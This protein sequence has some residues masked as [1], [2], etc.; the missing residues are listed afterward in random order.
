LICLLE[1]D[2]LITVLSEKQN[3]LKEILGSCFKTGNEYL[4]FCPK[5]NHHKRKLSVN[6]EKNAFK[7]WIC[8]YRSKSILSLIKS[9]GSQQ[10]LD[11]W[12]AITGEIDF[13]FEKQSIKSRLLD[14][15]KQEIKKGEYIQLPKEFISL[16]GN[17]SLAAGQARK[18]LYD[19]GVLEEDINYWKIG[20]AVEGEYCN[21]IIIPLCSNNGKVNFF[22]SRTYLN[23][24]PKYKNPSV[25]K[26]IVFNE[27][28]I[29]WNKPIVLVEGIFDAIKAGENSIPLL[30]S[31]LNENGILFSNLVKCKL[32]VYICL[33]QDAKKKEYGIIKKLLYFGL[34]VYKIDIG[35]F[36]DPGEMTK[37]Q[38]IKRKEKAIK[39]TE[40]K[41]MIYRMEN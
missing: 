11:K 30:G 29:D 19:R 39:I 1:C 28:M 10:L 7:C 8:G 35:E 20:F 17:F 33:D 24:I 26:D 3:I 41:L 34:E 37:K 40:E 4:Y 25:D 2:I 21:R 6:L 15:Q 27:I 23:E 22:V 12:I 18:Y 14:G 16:V 31:S 38:F 32:P 9:F 13:S 5:C 36:K